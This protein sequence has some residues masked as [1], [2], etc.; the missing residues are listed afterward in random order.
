M[1]RTTKNSSQIK[2]KFDFKDEEKLAERH[3][4][5]T[6]VPNNCERR[7]RRKSNHT[8]SI[9]KSGDASD[10]SKQDNRLMLNK[11]RRS[12]VR[13][14]TQSPKRKRKESTTLNEDLKKVSESQ[15]EES[16][17][18]VIVKKNRD[19]TTHNSITL[20]RTQQSDKN[21]Q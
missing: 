16:I 9:L 3:S 4:R 21:K 8:D 18:S 6:Q 1:R 11:K 15:I 2:I 7:S 17:G 12:L 13:T 14:Q 20:S 19:S 5:K 10:R